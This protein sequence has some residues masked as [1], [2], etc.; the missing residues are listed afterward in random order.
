MPIIKDKYGA[1]GESVRS[2]YVRRQAVQNT[3]TSIDYASMQNTQ[4]KRSILAEQV[5]S[6]NKIDETSNTIAEI[7]REVKTHIEGFKF[8]AIQTV[9]NFT[10]LLPGQSLLDIL[11]NHY[12]SDDTSSIVSLYWSTSPIADMTFSYTGGGTTGDVVEDTKGGDM[13]R[14]VVEN[15]PTDSSISIG[16]Y[17][18][19]ESFSN[20]GN[21]IYFYAVVSG[22]GPEITTIKKY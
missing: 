16:S 10:T 14:L 1:K 15:M 21:T 4:Q 3:N 19:I 2:K 22:A 17:G 11:I 7:N 5:K 6:V 20:I 18:L 8:P 9:Y 13:Y 12:N